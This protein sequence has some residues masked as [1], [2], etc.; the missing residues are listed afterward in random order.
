MHCFSRNV[1]KQVYIHEF[2]TSQWKFQLS[3]I[4][5]FGKMIRILR[6]STT[7]TN[8]DNMCTNIIYIPTWTLEPKIEANKPSKHY[9]HNLFD[10]GMWMLWAHSKNTCNPKTSTKRSSSRQHQP[11]KEQNEN[12]TTKTQEVGLRVVNFLL[13]FQNNPR[14]PTMVLGLGKIKLMSIRKMSS[15]MKVSY[16]NMWF[17]LL[18]SFFIKLNSHS[19]GSLLFS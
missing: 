15:W 2:S 12:K 16:D 9:E 18:H 3:F 17:L 5:R 4:L 19:Y 8:W 6:I 11:W 7:H 10:K 14:K 13:L 1:C